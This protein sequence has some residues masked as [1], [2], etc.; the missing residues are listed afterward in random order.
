MTKKNDTGS[1]AVQIEG[2]S[3]RIKSITEHLSTMKKDHSSRRGLLNLV[4]KR[5]KL[6]TYL[7][8]TKPN[9][10]VKVVNKLKLRK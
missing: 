10:Y 9:E 5:R 6:L 4:S 8:K 1:A 2:F 3:N 7:K